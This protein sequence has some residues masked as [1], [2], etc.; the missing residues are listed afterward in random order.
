MATPQWPSWLVPLYDGFRPRDVA[1]KHSFKPSVGPSI[2]RPKATGAPMRQQW[3]VLLRGTRYDD[4]I[5]FYEEDTRQGT[6]LADG[7]DPF[8]LEPAQMR[9]KRL[10]RFNTLTSTIWKVSLEVEVIGV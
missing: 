1:P 6:I 7:I 5:S 3:S 4:F 2:D 9:I 10:G 8:T